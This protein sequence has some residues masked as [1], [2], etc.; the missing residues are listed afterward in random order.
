MI[1]SYQ[2]LVNLSNEIL[3]AIGELDRAVD[4]KIKS[5]PEDGLDETIDNFS[6]EI[7]SLQNNLAEVGAENEFLSQS[8][9]ELNHQ[10]DSLKA[11]SGKLLEAVKADLEKIKT[12]IN[13]SN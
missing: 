3:K 7:N 1:N 5:A 10:I 8:N 2:K 13:A 6:R 12:I 4:Q 9:K 11:N